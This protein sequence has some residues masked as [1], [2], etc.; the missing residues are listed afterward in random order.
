MAVLWG[1]GEDIDFGN[2]QV[3]IATTNAI[4]F[5]SGFSRCSVQVPTAGNVETSNQFSGGA[6]TTAWF[7]CR[8]LLNA[9]ANTNNL[10]GVGLFGTNKGLFVGTDSSTANKV[11]LRKFDGTTSTQLAAESG[12][13][14]VNSTI[15]RVDMQVI[16]YGASATVNVY[17]NGNFVLTFTGDVTVSGVTNF[18]CV[19]LGRNTGTGAGIGACVSEVMVATDDLRAWPGLVTM[20]LTGAGTT[21]QW[22]GNT[23]SNV[24][25]TSFSDTAPMSD[26]TNGQLQEFNVTDFPAGSYTI[27][28]VKQTARCAKSASPAVAQI[29]LGYNSG[30]SVAYGTGATKAVTTAYASYEQLDLVNPVTGV[31]FVQSDMNALQLDTKAVT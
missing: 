23:F 29:E 8:L 15:H 6:I 31:A 30:G 16:S 1:G 22:T 17:I 26:N 14:W 20:A 21:N 2:G 27:Q 4:T 19:A 28:A 18:D 3:A 25:G 24:N 11:A 7:S 5:R 10:V 12:T 13:S 9:P